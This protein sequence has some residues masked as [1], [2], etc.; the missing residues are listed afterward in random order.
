VKTTF[1]VVVV[2]V[3]VDVV[4]IKVMRTVMKAGEYS[5]NVM[6]IFCTRSIIIYMDVG[7]SADVDDE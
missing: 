3:V 5:E 1:S 4:F 7:G 6:T 2:V